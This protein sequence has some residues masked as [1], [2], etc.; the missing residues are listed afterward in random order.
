VTILLREALNAASRTT[1]TAFVRV[2]PIK[3]ITVAYPFSD[4]EYAANCWRNDTYDYSIVSTQTS[5]IAREALDK[6]VDKGLYGCESAE[7]DASPRESDSS[8]NGKSEEYC[9]YVYS[10][11]LASE[12]LLHTSLERKLSPTRAWVEVTARVQPNG[13]VLELLPYVRPIGFE[14]PTGLFL[15]FE[16]HWPIPDWACGVIAVVPGQEILSVDGCTK[17]ICTKPLQNRFFQEVRSALSKAPIGAIEGNSIGP[18][19]TLLTREMQPSLVLG[20]PY[21]E[22]ST[23]LV[24][25]YSADA[26]SVLQDV[27]SDTRGTGHGMNLYL[28]IAHILTVTPNKLDLCKEPTPGQTQMYA[29]VMA[30]TLA[31]IIVD[32]CNDIHGQMREQV[33]H[34]SMVEGAVR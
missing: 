18:D 26:D 22:C 24:R 13:R 8:A 9:K 28:N 20:E 32:A 12:D 30:T 21:Y 31:K 16:V 10:E 34:A 25:P 15:G 3:P 2:A 33:C 29:T 7:P 27:L 14:T 17:S 4:R 5:H 1:Q 6:L 23:Y 11:P 19:E